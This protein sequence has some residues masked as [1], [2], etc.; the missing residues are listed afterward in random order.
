MSNE[1]G[2]VNFALGYNRDIYFLLTANLNSRIE[3]RDHPVD[4]VVSFLSTTTTFSPFA[5]LSFKSQTHRLSPRPKKVSVISVEPEFGRHFVHEEDSKKQKA[6][7]HAHS[8]QIVRI[9]GH[10][11]STHLSLPP[12]FLIYIR[13]HNLNF[14]HLLLLLIYYSQRTHTA[15]S[16]LHSALLLLW[17]YYI[18]RRA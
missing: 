14:Q 3:R 16:R 8:L 13:T 9:W 18:L 7:A 10:R 2:H 15:R 6:G 12:F 4:F 5:F 1:E 11:E 17:K